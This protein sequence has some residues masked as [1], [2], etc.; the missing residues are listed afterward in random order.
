ML[1]FSISAE[2]V[3]ILSTRLTDAFPGAIV[4]YDPDESTATVADEFATAAQAIIASGFDPTKDELKTHAAAVRYAKEIAGCAVGGVTYP[5]DRDTQAKL[6]A[7]ALFAQV[8]NTQ[9][10]RWKLADGSFSD[11]L[12]AAQ[13]I[14][15]AAAVGGYVNS[16]FAEEAAA[17]AEIESGTITTREDVDA[18]FSE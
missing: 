9:M 6:T 15:I 1:T 18:A 14:A 13:M 16:C 12:S 3:G 2:N 10:F 8:D 4:A 17:V 11:E 5:S 7:A